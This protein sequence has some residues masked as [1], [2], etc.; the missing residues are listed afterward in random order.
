MSLTLP[1]S[2]VKIS[3]ESYHVKD[4]KKGTFGEVSKIKEEFE[5]FM[6]S[7]DQENVIMAILELSD[8]LGAIEGYIGK[9]NLK[10][11]DIIKMKDATKRAFKNGERK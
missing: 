1:Y 2:S 7:I 8:M 6:D 5:E 4:I 10:L 11:E 3:P 9:F